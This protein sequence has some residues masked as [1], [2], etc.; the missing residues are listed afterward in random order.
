[1]ATPAATRAIRVTL[2]DNSVRHFS[3]ADTVTL[4]NALG[5]ALYPGAEPDTTSSGGTVPP[6][7]PTAP[8]FTVTAPY[9]RPVPYPIAI[10]ASYG[11]SYLNHAEARQLIV[12]LLLAIDRSEELA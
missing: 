6:L 9:D 8:E 10:C 11:G 2:P 4:Y 12:D 3:E 5:E 1:M 7:S